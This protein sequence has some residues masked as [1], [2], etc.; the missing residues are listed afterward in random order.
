MTDD[1]LNSKLDSVSKIFKLTEDLDPFVEKKWKRIFLQNGHYMPDRYFCAMQQA[2]LRIGETGAMLQF[3]IEDDNLRYPVSFL[4][5]DAFS[6]TVLAPR[7][8]AADFEEYVVFGFSLTWGLWADGNNAAILSGDQAFTDA[9]FDTFGG[10][11]CLKEDVERYIGMF[12]SNFQ[13]N[14]ISLVRSF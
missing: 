11:G 10:E 5:M 1:F 2:L 8:G 12:E 7:E 13:S 6:E 4:S 14:F 9:F 3:L